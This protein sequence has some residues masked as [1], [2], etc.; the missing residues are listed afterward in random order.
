VRIYYDHQLTSL[1]DAGGAS[2]YHYEL[3]R[4]LDAVPEVQTTT[5]L[6]FN[7]TVYPY[8]QLVSSKT[9]VVGFQGPLHKGA[10]R[11]AVNE[12]LA[13]VVAPFCGKF[14]IYH[15]SHHRILPFVSACRIVVTHHDCIYERFPVFRYVK[16]VLRAK[17]KLFAAADLIICISESSRADLLHFYDVDPV[18][19]RVVHEGFTRLPRSPEGARQLLAARIRR[20][21]I[22][23]VSGRSMYKNF[24]GLLQAF[25]DTRLH[26]TME[27]LIVGG[28]PLTAD[29]L[30][31]I[32]KL[33]IGES[34][35]AIPLADEG[36]L[37]EA[38]AGA[39]LL[40]YPSLFEGFGLPPLE[41]MSF[42]CPVL[43]CNTSSLP[44]ICGDA[45]FYYEK[46]EPDSLRDALL[47]AVFDEPARAAAIQRGYQVASRYSWESCADR[48]LALYREVL[49]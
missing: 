33:G 35:A 14:D 22:L 44:E 17:K 12:A 42:G 37:A 24:R 32:K 13:N 16:Q 5:F 1:Q 4:C 6:G 11:Y 15:P 23:Y 25:R 31:L 48:T 49:A 21:Y 36:L 2:R 43:V 34:I 39:R 7:S 30:A 9:K 8:L 38:Y 28:G 3:L 41:A 46:D 26:E 27:L 18:K 29:E 20:N 40:A 19:T 47:C 45:P 10:K